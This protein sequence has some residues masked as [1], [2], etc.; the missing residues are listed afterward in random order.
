M[1][2]LF[3][4]LFVSL[5][6]VVSLANVTAD[7]EFILNH[8]DG[9]SAKVQLGTLINKTPNLLIAKYSYAVQGG[10]TAAAISLLTDLKKPNSYAKLPNKAIITGVF[11]N[12]LTAP[13]SATPTTT[14]IA[15]QSAAAGD[16]LAGRT[17]QT[18]YTFI[19]GIPT[20]G[21]T[22]TFIKLSAEKTIKAVVGPSTLGSPPLT[23]GKFN[24]YI[25]YIIGD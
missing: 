17:T 24:V 4:V 15:L 3:V 23:A 25:R 18:M 6:S 11:V 7:Q 10:S 16:L 12:T 20:E 19:Q 9:P 14:T 8:A 22:S 2:N 13:T 1:K 21:T 5:L